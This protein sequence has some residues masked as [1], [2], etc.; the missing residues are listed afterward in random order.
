M[1]IFDGMEKT[2]GHMSN[3]ATTE[4][5]L[6]LAN[7]ARLY[8]AAMDLAKDET[9]STDPVSRLATRLRILA[10]IAARWGD[11]RKEFVHKADYIELAETWIWRVAEQD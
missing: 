7:T 11:L 9:P 1:L 8:T 2:M 4:V 6:V 10:Q 5:D 3:H